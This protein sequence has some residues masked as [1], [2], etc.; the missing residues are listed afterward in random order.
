MK[1]LFLSLFGIIALSS[2][3]A[4]GTWNQKN[5]FPGN[6]RSRAVCF[7]IGSYGYFGTGNHS[8]GSIE[9]SDFWQYDADNDSWLQ[10]ANVPSGMQAAIGSSID[11]KGY[12]GLGW[13]ASNAHLDFYEYNPSTNTWASKASYNGNMTNDATSIG[14]GNIIFA[15]LGAQPYS[16][17]HWDDWKSYNP[18]T[19]SWSS[20]AIFPG[21][22][23]RNAGSFKIGSDL[24]VGG[25]QLEGGGAGLDYYKYNVS[26]NSWSA[27]ASCP[28]TNNSSTRN[29]G[30][31]LN[32]KGYFVLN[33]GLW[34]YD[35]MM[36]SWSSYPL[37]F[38]ASMAGTFV[39]NNKVYVILANTKEVWEWTPCSN[40]SGVDVQSACESYTW[41]D[42]NTYTS[43][44]NTATHILPNAAGCD[45]VITLDLTINYPNTGTDVQTACDSYTWIDGNTY[46][47]SNNSA[48]WVTTNAAGCDSI[49]TIDL[50][51]IPLPDN[52]ITENGDIISAN[53]LNASYQWLDCD[54][55]NI[56]ING[57][58][59]QIYSPTT[60][61]NYAVEVS[62]N[63]CTDT[64]TCSY[65]DFTSLEE[66]NSSL[67]RVYPNPSNNNLKI[68]G[69]EK[70]K[71]V[72]T[73]EITSI[74][75]ARLAKRDVYSP[76]IDIS[77]LDN[78][79]YL[80]VISHENGTEKIRFIKN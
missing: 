79:I 36:D 77:S 52:G 5:D 41:I 46:T 72:K 48:T 56:P 54:N 75:G 19:N 10:R 64:S 34:E 69:I 27:I 60:T 80:F 62:L 12:V 28:S 55:N 18:T 9:T 40:S 4:Q 11:G 8:G 20:M 15:G 78:G 70:L 59:N 73:F 65:V 53:Q 6:A 23:R 42:G 49:V 3:H 57:E 16:S 61:G 50:I 76:L 25:G 32:G 47:Q 13:W 30:F 33:D 43:N 1:N 26:L 63:G 7:S 71:N 39:I 24:F 74:T 22:D 58:T 29:A 31:G 68:L 67:V 14:L 44:D 35:P 2:I 38:S 45:S 66:L 21:I 17:N 37:P 51:I